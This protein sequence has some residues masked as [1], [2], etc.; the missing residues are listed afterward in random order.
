MSQNFVTNTPPSTTS[1]S[2]FATQTDDRS[3]A[4]L[5]MHSG[6]VRPPY[7]KAGTAWL[8][9]DGSPWVLYFYDGAQDVQLATVD[10]VTHVISWNLADSYDPDLAA[11]AGLS[12]TKNDQLVYR[13]GAWAA[14]PGLLSGLR[15]RLINPLF[16]V[17]FQAQNTGVTAD[18]RHVV[19]GWVLSHSNDVTT[20]TLSRVTG[21]SVPYSLRY[22]VTTGSDP[23]LAAGAYAAIETAVEGNDLADALWGTA[24]AKPVWIAG[25]VMAPT[26]G[27]YCVSLCNSDN[28]RSYV[29]EVD[30]IADTWVDFEVEVPGDTAGTWLK[31]QGIGT[32]LRFCVAGGANFETAAD[33]WAGGNFLVTANQ[34][35][36]TETN[37]NQYRIEN[38]RLSVGAPVGQDWI[39]YNNELLRCQR[40]YQVHTHRLRWDQAIAG[41][42]VGQI[43]PMPQAMRA[44]PTVVIDQL[45]AI[46]MQ[47]INVYGVSS[48]SMQ[49]DYGGSAAGGASDYRFNVRLNAR[50]I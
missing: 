2:A 6:A 38:V 28:S 22:A 35:N 12:P 24:N 48:Y 33:A 13:D 50:L 8:K 39:G 42:V 3:D 44:T 5:T 16:Y 25:R 4:L 29:F 46:N 14:V 47:S 15:N 26:T 20:Q 32:R 36:G 11:I 17:D 49:I 40:Y 18:A 27:V 1:G 10:P 23:S 21:D 41:E 7:A 31:N 37:G 34:A 19:E 43:L 30:C 45:D 9:N